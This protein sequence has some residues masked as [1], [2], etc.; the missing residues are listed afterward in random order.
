[1]GLEFHSDYSTGTLLSKTTNDVNLVQ[2]GLTLLSDCVREPV[3]AIAMF[4]LS[5][6]YGLETDMPYPRCSSR[7]SS[8]FLRV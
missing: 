8:L 2:Q 6:L 1:M 5:L 7:W 3:S 4:A